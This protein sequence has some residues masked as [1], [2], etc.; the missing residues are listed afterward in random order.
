MRARRSLTWASRGGHVGLQPRAGDFEIDDLGASRGLGC[1][2]RLARTDLGR[3]QDGARLLLGLGDETGGRLLGLGDGGV[4]RALGQHQR[5]PGGAVGLGAFQGPLLGSHGPLC[6][7]AEAVLQGGDGGGHTLDEV[8]DLVA[9][10]AAPLFAE[11][12]LAELLRCQ[13]HENRC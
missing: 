3:E 1:R 9:A 13:L 4:G 6:H 11:L 5:A 7:L 2:H 12:D 8:V 10:V